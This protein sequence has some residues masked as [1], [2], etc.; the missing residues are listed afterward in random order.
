MKK[1]FLLR[2]SGLVT[3]LLF[4]SRITNLA[5]SPNLDP[6]PPN[7]KDPKVVCELVCPGTL[8]FTLASGECQRVVSYA[9]T[10]TGDCSGS[11]PVQTSGLPSGSAFPIGTT[12]NCFTV[13]LP[14]LGLPDG[15]IS[16]CFDVV[17]SAFPNPTPFITCNDLVYI[18][19]DENCQHCISAESVLEGGPYGCYDNYLVELDKTP[20]F[21]NG[22]WSSGCVGASD[23]GKTYQV[24]ITEP[25]FGNKCWGSLKVEDKLAPVLACPSAI[26]P[27]NF[28]SFAPEYVQTATFTLKFAAASGDL[29]KTLNPGENF[30]FNIPVDFDAVVNDVD[31]R[32]KITNALAWNMQIELVSPSGTSALIWDAMG[33]CGVSAPVFARFDD[34]G[35]ASNQCADI[36]ADLNL[37]LMSVMGFDSLEAF[38]GEN[39]EGIWQIRIS[40]PDLQGFGQ[41]AV[42]EIAELYIN[43][44]GQFSAGFPNNL[45]GNCVQALGNNQYLVPAGCGD[46]QLDNCSNVTLSYLD[47]TIPDTCGSGLTGHINREWTAVDAYGNSS[48]CIQRIDQLRPGLTDV[49]TPSD[50]DGIDAPAFDCTGSMP[51]LNGH[52]NPTPDWIES[53]GLPG[54]PSVFGQPSGCSINWDYQD[55]PIVVC[56]G[57]IKYRR[58]WTII[59][60]CTGEMIMHN[61]I[62]KV[63]DNQGPSLTCPQNLSVSTDVFTC[64][65]TV[66][67]PD[68]IITDGCSRIKTTHVTVTGQQAGVQTLDGSLMNF[69]GNNLSDPDTLAVFGF[70]NCLSKGSHTVEY[71]AEDDCGNTGTCAFQLT[72]IDNVPPTAV[73][74]AKSTVAIGVDDPSDCFGPAGP[75]GNPAGLNSC[76]FAGISWV[77]A[78]AFDNGSYDACGNVKFTV[79]RM[80]PYSDCIL[81]LNSTNGQTPCNDVFPDFPSEFERAISEQDS[82]KFYACEV[83]TI[84]PVILRVYQLEA[85]GSFS[86]YPN[87]TPIYNE[88]IVEVEVADKIKPVCSAPQ[89]V[90]VTCEQ[91]DPS[92]LA[93][94][95]PVLTDNCCLDTNQNYQGQCGLSQTLGYASFDTLCS[96]GTLLR[97]F[98]AFDCNGNSSQCTQRIFVNYSQNYYVHFPDDVIVNACNGT[99]IYGEPQ[100]FGEDCELLATAY[101]DQIIDVVPDAC[102]RIQRTWTVINWCTYNPGL[103]STI[104][105][106]P[107]PNAINNH[108][109]NLPGPIVSACDAVAPWNPTIVK[110]SPVDPAETN[111]CSFWDANNNSYKY[112]QVIK[113]IDTT[114]P[115]FAN[116]PAN[117]VTYTDNTQNDPT[118]WHQVFNPNLPA[119][120]LTEME[121]NLSIT[122]SDDCAGANLALAFLLF[123]DLDGDG[124]QE[125]VINSNNLP[126]ADT[127]LY[128]NVSTPGYLGGTPVNFDTRAVPTSQKWHFSLQNTVTLNQRTSAVRWNTAQ[129]P[130]TF[131]VP[132]LPEGT[133]K[134]K[135]IASDLCGNESVCEHTFTITQGPSS[136]IDLLD[137]DGFAL[138]QNEP[139]PFNSQTK[140]GFRLPEAAEATLS[141]F[142]T[143]GRLVFAKTDHFRQGLN[144]VSMEGTGVLTPGVLYYKLESGAHVAWKKMV[145]IR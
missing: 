16:C 85:D 55:F 90:T 42:V 30:T 74:D 14:P 73:C 88:C 68:L 133:H 5:A 139:N 120:D 45:S 95:L 26:L 132:Q 82:I 71:Y 65:A 53:Q 138:Y 40:N 145:L 104:V 69:P 50:Y 123:L 67:L 7:L 61:Q 23:I 128:N 92:L 79:R 100:F 52:P 143:E 8:S 44:T 17:V 98:T 56:D 114:D 21:G 116:C 46:P 10:T 32:V 38:D 110:I 4:L 39:A 35:L 22:P 62:I 51:T 94:G 109:A 108:P 77:K 122:S 78:A 60:W 130:G 137:T 34:E 80:A 2:L 113:I 12:T 134:I 3:G 144:S 111:Y 72:V 63:V 142:D 76:E 112:T 54:Y 115:V 33:G 125:T 99:G 140:I 47:N 102:F 24:R 141:V 9:V 36:G 135:W 41:V 105:P 119:E 59:D 83:G 87:G 101:E 121:A 6:G 127:I 66:D 28:P 48:T 57:T 64:C 19:V 20:P 81:A 97:R 106:N 103:P 107:N 49:V 86:L 91:F 25:V 70:P 13:D 58:E 96:K 126:G 129:A 18:A 75:N 117:T 37:D 15:D 29:P 131:V 118:L 89:D 43:M 31:C 1:I 27:C 11:I 93:Y 84:Q 136:G 124:T